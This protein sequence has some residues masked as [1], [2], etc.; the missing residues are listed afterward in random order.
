M[1]PKRTLSFFFIVCFLMLD[2]PQIQ[3]KGGGKKF[4]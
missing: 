3:K 1:E 4:S 2:A